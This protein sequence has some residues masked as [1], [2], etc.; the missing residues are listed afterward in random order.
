MNESF[1]GE[2]DAFV[3]MVDPRKAMWD[4]SLE[5]WLGVRQGNR[6]CGFLL[7]CRAERPILGKR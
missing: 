2:I 6:V 1:D 7:P 4:E 5:R 3:I